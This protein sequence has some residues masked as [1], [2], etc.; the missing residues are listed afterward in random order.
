VHEKRE[1]S[2]G[3]VFKV[4]FFVEFPE[5]NTPFSRDGNHA[6][7]IVRA[8]ALCGKDSVGNVWF[9]R[10]PEIPFAS[11]SLDA[12]RRWMLG[13]GKTDEVVLEA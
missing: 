13:I 4:V 11:S 6:R 9:N 10:V 7:R 12:C 3:V 8:V 5:E 2:T 1:D